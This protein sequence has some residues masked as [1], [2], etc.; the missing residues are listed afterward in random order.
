MKKR[1]YA[2]LISLGSL[3][4][5]VALLAMTGCETKSTEELAVTVTPDYISLG[6]GQS[7]TLTASGWNNYR[8]TCDR[9][10]GVLSAPVGERVVYRATTGGG[11]RQ[12][13]IVSAAGVAGA[14]GGTNNNSTIPVGVA[15]IIQN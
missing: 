3:C 1:N 10:L 6:S 7:V 8:W 11:V 14:T 12:E 15:I 5:M 9:S 2:L 13:I 4:A